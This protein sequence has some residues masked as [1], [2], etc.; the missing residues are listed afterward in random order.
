MAPL[1]GGSTSLR[2]PPQEGIVKRSLISSISMMLALGAMVAACGD[3]DSTADGGTGGS[4]GSAGS[5]GTG[6]GGTGGGGTGGGAGDAGTSTGYSWIAIVDN[7]K[8]PACTGSGPGADIDSI[9]LMRAGGTTVAGVGKNG[10]AMLTSQ[11]GGTPCTMC[12]SAACK[13]SDSAAAVRAEGIPNAMVLMVGDDSGY[14]SLN[15]QIL[16]LQVGSANGGGTAQEI[17]SGDTIKVHEVD[18][19]NVTDGTAFAGCMCAPEKYTV[20]AYK[21]INDMTGRVQLT[22]SGSYAA[23]N[24]SMCGGATPSGSLGCGTTSFTVP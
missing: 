1:V 22:P 15:S 19:T 24:A 12:G 4:G 9:D 14:V 2:Q 16:W 10:S 11:P 8:M 5:G 21:A 7:D 20:F 23:D 3:D 6:G 18:R 13:Y 17:K